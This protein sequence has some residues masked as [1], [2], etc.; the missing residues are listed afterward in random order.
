LIAGPF[1]FKPVAFFATT[2]AERAVPQ[3]SFTGSGPEGP[4]PAS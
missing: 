1:G 4:T 3:V 2:D